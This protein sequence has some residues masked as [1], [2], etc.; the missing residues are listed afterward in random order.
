MFCV[1]F[2]RCAFW[3]ASSTNQANAD[4]SQVD[5]FV[6]WFSAGVRALD[7]RDPYALRE[8][9]HYI[10]ATNKNTRPSCPTDGKAIISG[11]SEQHCKTAIVTNAVEVDDRGYVSQLCLYGLPQQYRQAYR[12]TE[13]RCTPD[14]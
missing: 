6:A 14:S 13:W 3:S 12:R 2:A 4:L 8:I 5:F 11:K 10:P 1:A 7:L 9:R